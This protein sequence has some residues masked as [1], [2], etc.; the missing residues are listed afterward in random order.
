MIIDYNVP[1]WKP[2]YL[3]FKD[4][5]NVSPDLT[6]LKTTPYP[7][8]AI[9]RRFWNP[10][11]ECFIYVV[12]DSSRGA[13]TI[14]AT[15]LG[16]ISIAAGAMCYV[17]EFGYNTSLT[18]PTT[19]TFQVYNVYASNTAGADTGEKNAMA[20]YSITSPATVSGQPAVK[21]WALV[22]L[23]VCETY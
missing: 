1:E 23:A 15:P 2:N 9:G 22:K 14:P 10:L 19:A 13:A 11:G 17:E 18:V 16:A 12:C 8:T 4:A 7:V 6:K 20:L 5:G 21:S 3:A